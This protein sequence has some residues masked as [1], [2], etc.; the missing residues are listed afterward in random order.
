MIRFLFD[1]YFKLRGT[2]GSGLLLSGF[3]LLFIG[4]V[5]L[6]F[7]EILIA[8]IASIFIVGGLLSLYFGW[9]LRKEKANYH[10]IEIN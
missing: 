9:K 1:P 8:F 6:V 4:L 10:R 3:L 7:P 5:I 2:H